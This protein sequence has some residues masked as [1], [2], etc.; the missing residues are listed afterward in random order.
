MRRWA[1]AGWAAA[2]L[3]IYVYAQTAAPAF[4][5]AS[6][7]LTDPAHKPDENRHAHRI[8]TTPGNVVM[9]DV[10]LTEAIQWAYK[11]ESYQVSGPAWMPQTPFEIVAKAAGP[12]TD[13]EMRAMM[14]TLL[15]NRFGLQAHREDKE[16]SGMALLV[17]KSGPKLKPA[18][19]QGESVFEPAPKKMQIHMGRMSMR[20]FAALLSE[21]MRKPVVDLTGLPGEFDFTIDGSNYAP[22]P[23]ATGQKCD[24]PDEIYMVTRAVQDQLGL[25]LEPRKLTINMVVV[26][27][28]EKVPTEN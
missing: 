17:A 23:C 21:P 7:H 6:V 10:G 12:A 2:C 26:D 20:E 8:H 11:V 5:V 4:E 22:P 14:R 9:R 19:G 24:E 27:H 28:I 15:A 25:R 13:D 16:M 18:D 3:T 1:L